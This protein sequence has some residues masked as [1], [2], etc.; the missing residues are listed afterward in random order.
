MF[1]GLLF[2]IVLLSQFSSGRS[3][4]TNDA[5]QVIP[6]NTPPAVLVTTID[7][8]WSEE[9]RSMIVDNR[10]QYAA[11]HGKCWRQSECRAF[12]ASL[13]S[14][15]GYATFL[16]NITDY[17]L[18]EDHVPDSWSKIP[19]VRHAMTL[20]PHTQYF[21]YLDRTSV[22]TNPILSL[23][24]HITKHSRLESLMIA[25]QPIVPPDSVIRTLHSRR[26]DR[27]DFIVTQD[28][29]GLSQA[30]F[31]VRHGIWAQ[32]FLD[33]WYDPL[34]RSYNFQRAEGHALEHL[35]QW[36]GT[37]L[38]R[39]AIVPQKIMNSYISGK[40]LEQYTDGDFVANAPACGLP[41][42]PTCE[43][44]LRPYYNVFKGILRPELSSGH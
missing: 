19:A 39:I 34:Y 27:V 35:V 22:I 40:A 44:A 28:H 12:K 17:A 4:R 20:Y 42:Q 15:L 25:D 13:T 2:F 31:L 1:T 24:E 26:A 38:A 18:N 7:P 23:H 6:P 14:F 11:Y 32:F 37:I 43:T 9:F 33:S 5:Q 21:F 29:E 3:S 41:N 36:H 30:S 8:G 10:R 16:P